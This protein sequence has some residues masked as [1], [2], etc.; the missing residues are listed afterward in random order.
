MSS[1][2]HGAQRKQGGGEMR[3]ELEEE[4]VRHRDQ[5]VSV[6]GLSGRDGV[7]HRVNDQVGVLESRP[8]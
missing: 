8:A 3:E 5:Q 2:V 7:H 6:L 4:H 1:S